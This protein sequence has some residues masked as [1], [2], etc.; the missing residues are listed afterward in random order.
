MT[1]TRERLTRECL[2]VTAGALFWNL[3]GVTR[4]THFRAVLDGSEA[5]V[6]GLLATFTVGISKAGFSGASLLSVAIF[7]HLFG[8]KVQAGLALPLLIVA[9]L[10]VYPAFRKHGSWSDVW[11]LLPAALVGVAIGWWGL[12]VLEKNL[13]ERL[14]GV[15]ILVML[16]LLSVKLVHPVWLKRMADH[17][18]FGTAAGVTGGATSA[19]ANAAGPIIQ[20][21]LLSRQI[22][23]MELIGIGARFFLLINLIKVPLN[24]GLG[25][26]TA[27]TLLTGLWL[28]P[29]IVAG[30]LAGKWLLKRVPQRAFEWMIVGFAALAAAR[31]LI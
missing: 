23:K 4:A 9:D 6:L 20:L 31:M 14:I 18:A 26:I 30:V 21:Y 19:L 15:T 25:L 22:P 16:G 24:R 13:T 5:W 7:T 12:A 3:A 10:I 8:P 11:R 28:S 29:G 27:E 17:R 2:K 1:F